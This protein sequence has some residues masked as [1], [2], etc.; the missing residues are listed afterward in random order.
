MDLVV[1]FVGAD[2][3]IVRWLTVVSKIYICIVKPRMIGLLMS[4]LRWVPD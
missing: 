2:V 3:E 1:D 4:C